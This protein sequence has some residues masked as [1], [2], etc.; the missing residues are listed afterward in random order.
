[1]SEEIY[2]ISS[3]PTF[4]IKNIKRKPQKKTTERPWR[5][6]RTLST[7]ILDEWGVK[8]Q[9][10]FTG[11]EKVLKLTTLNTKMNLQMQKSRECLE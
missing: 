8:V 6:W 1:L 11:S 9:T 3:V 10:G 5:R 7:S 2:E 4:V